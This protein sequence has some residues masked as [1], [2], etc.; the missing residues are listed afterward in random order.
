[1]ALKTKILIWMNK[2]NKKLSSNWFVS[3]YLFLNNIIK[4]KTTKKRGKKIMM[5]NHHKKLTMKMKKGKK[6]KNKETKMKTRKRMVEVVKVRRMRK[7]MAKTKRKRRR[8]KKRRKR[9][10]F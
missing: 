10:F 3:L 8:R 2:I 6:G 1:M 9:K 7:A 4:I 5:K